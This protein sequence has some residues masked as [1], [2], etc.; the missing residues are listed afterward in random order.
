MSSNC[1]VNR[2]TFLKFGQPGTVLAAMK[3]TVL[4]PSVRQRD[5]YTSFVLSRHGIGP[6]DLPP[7]RSIQLS[8]RDE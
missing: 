7:T 5:I 8:H 3:P 4:R 6:V 2:R 1:D